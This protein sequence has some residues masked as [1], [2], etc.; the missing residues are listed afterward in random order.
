MNVGERIKFS[1][2]A[3]KEME[4][5]IQKIFP[6]KVYLTVDF[7]NHP[8]KTVVRRVSELEGKVPARKKKKEKGK[9]KEKKERG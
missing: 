2:G 3:G 1:F 5:V 4:G 7:P 9:E 8:G 6:K